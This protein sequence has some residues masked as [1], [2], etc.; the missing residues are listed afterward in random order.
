MQVLEAL[1][2]KGIAIRVASPKLVMEVRASSRPRSLA[3]I[4]IWSLQMC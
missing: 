2:T 1:K 4:S 3:S